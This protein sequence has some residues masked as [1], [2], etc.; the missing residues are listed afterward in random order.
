MGGVVKETSFEEKNNA[1]KISILTAPKQ[2]Y[3][4]LGKQSRSKATQQKGKPNYNACAKSVPLF[5]SCT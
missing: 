5:L 3:H 1:E 4:V 2:C